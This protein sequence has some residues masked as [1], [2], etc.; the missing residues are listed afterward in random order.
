MTKPLRIEGVSKRYGDTW[1]LR[2]INLEAEMGILGLLGPNGAGKSTLMHIVATYLKPTDGTVMWQGTNIVETP[3]AVRPMLGYLPQDFGVY[4][5]LTAAE[6]LEY[7]AVL[8]GVGDGA[9]AQDRINELLSLVNLADAR[10]R[11]LA[12][13]SGGMRQ[14][15][16][17]AQALLN[18]PE[19]LIVDEPT[20]GLDPEERVRFQNVLIELATDRV[21]ILST[22]IVGDIEATASYVAVMN[23]GQ[24]LAHA[25][26]ETLLSEVEGTVWTWIAGR[27]TLPEIKRRYHVSGT[28]QRRDGI[29]VRVVADSQP[30]A[31]A[32]STTP[33]LNDAYLH[34]VNGDR[35]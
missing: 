33:M 4:G 10:D 26:P 29:Q 24:L 23:D 13:Y 35:R 11:R 19:L 9:A 7:M 30:T 3:T 27:D 1:A 12:T 17:I 25:S 20:A 15:I 18:D 31:D 5:K 21:I 16:G 28:A 34:I 22:H 8:R 6:F 14:R 2:E 32:T